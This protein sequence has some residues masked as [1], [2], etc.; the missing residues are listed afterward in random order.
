MSTL[1]DAIDLRYRREHRIQSAMLEL[2]HACPCRCV[3]CYLHRARGDEL[4]T[5]EVVD[6]LRQ[7]REMGTINLGITGGEPMV[8]ADLWEIL[9]AA[10]RE[11]FFVTLLTTGLLIGP[12]QA[13]LLREHGVRSVEISLLGATAPTHDAI[14][15]RRGAFDHA[16]RAAELLR[17]EGLLVCFKT[18]VLRPNQY[19]L[20]AMAALAARLGV[21]F[22]ANAIVAPR[23]DGGR[24]PQRSALSE[25]EVARLDPALLQGG[26]IPD[27]DTVA[28]AV[29]VCRAGSTVAGFSP[30]GDVYPCILMPARVGN[31]RQARLDE[32]WRRRPH[33]FL[34]RLRAARPE[35]A[36][37]CHGCSLRRQCRRCP[38]VAYLEEG[39]L[40]LPSPSACAEARGRARAVAPGSAPPLPGGK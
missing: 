27:E 11:H 21:E 18:T 40:L 23:T 31:V 29:L 28:G 8:R 26:L 39:E 13:V 25:D 38:G 35:D 7:L 4:T 12:E 16:V 15:R 32:L 24:V 33:P 3:H 19:E 1:R 5:A 14:M 9:A 10:H 22:S 30:R 34:E 20:P 2:T 17:W 36:A 6:L 37:A